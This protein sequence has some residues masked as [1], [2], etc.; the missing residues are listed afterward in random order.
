MKM[1][2]TLIMNF[3]EATS[4]KATY[5]REGINRSAK[6][7]AAVPKTRS[8]MMG[9]W[10]IIEREPVEQRYLFLIFI[11]QHGEAKA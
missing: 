5:D 9:C 4:Q 10:R 7:L 8:T 6:Q 11:Y 2:L 3:E 1:D